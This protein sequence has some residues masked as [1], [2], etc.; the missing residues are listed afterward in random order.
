MTF[1]LFSTIKHRGVSCTIAEL[2]FRKGAEAF[3][4]LRSDDGTLHRVPFCDVF[5]PP[6]P[7]F[8][9]LGAEADPIRAVDLQTIGRAPRRVPAP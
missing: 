8:H 9:W 4:T 6:P 1:N 7:P 2:E 5:L 3:V